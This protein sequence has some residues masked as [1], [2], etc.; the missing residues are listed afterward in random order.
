MFMNVS[1]LVANLLA[2]FRA[3][4]YYQQQ[5]SARQSWKWQCLE[6]GQFDEVSFTLLH[7]R[8]VSPVSISDDIIRII[9]GYSCNRDH[10]QV[11]NNTLIHNEVSCNESIIILGCEQLGFLQSHCIF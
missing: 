5:R 1:Y 6:R 10:F 7:H 3:F 11:T 9:Q 2:V 8:N 4:K